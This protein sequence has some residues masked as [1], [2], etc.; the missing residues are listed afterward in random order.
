MRCSTCG[1]LNE[2]GAINCGECDEPIAQKVGCGADSIE[3][4]DAI[5]D[6]LRW[7][8]ALPGIAIIG[9]IVDRQLEIAGFNDVSSGIVFPSAIALTIFVAAHVAAFAAP[10]YRKHVGLAIAFGEFAT[11]FGPFLTVTIFR[12]QSSFYP[13]PSILVLYLVFPMVGV[14]AAARTLFGSAT[15]VD[16]PMHAIGLPMT[17]PRLRW[18]LAISSALG[19]GAAFDAIVM[20]AS[21]LWRPYLPMGTAN[22]LIAVIEAAITVALVAEY[23]PA[24]KIVAARVVAGAY[25][26]ISVASILYLAF[27]FMRYAPV[28]DLIALEWANYTLLFAASIIGTVLGLRAAARWI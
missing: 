4:L 15:L 20:G 22:A 9:A 7:T 16:K 25:V 3:W 1:A 10:S 13:A 8:V 26:T 27:L 11:I 14:A 6:W 12:Y 5:P 24:K 23:A 21:A 19:A 17:D 28:Y 18:F 2:D